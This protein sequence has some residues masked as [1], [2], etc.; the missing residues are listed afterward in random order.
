MPRPFG[1]LL[2]SKTAG[3][4][5]ES[6]P[7]AIAA[8]QRLARASQQPS[9]SSPAFQVEAS[10]DAT[11]FTPHKLAQFRVIVLQHV[12][13]EFL[14]ASQLDALRGFV[15][16]GGGVVGIHT[17]TTGMPSCES[18]CVDKEAWYQGLIGA[19]FDGH[20]EPQDGI[21]RVQSASHPILTRGAHGRDDGLETF[22]QSSMTRHW[23]DE[24]YN[25]KK[26]PGGNA[27]LTVLLSVDETSYEGGRL[28]D[29]HPL[30]WCQEFEGGR[31]FQTALG[32]FDAAYE[33]D[34][35]MGQA[36][37]GLLWA[38]GLL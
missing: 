38:A 19:A 37:S 18:G 28:G 3:Y 16:A 26:S 35:F 25:F 17:A 34:M 30:T 20:P 21:I 10:E 5:H 14:D 6:I 15:R 27:N 32:H 22:D 12:T 24:W 31:V 2:F 7:A 13:G 8:W 11:L 36:L 1:V 33:D 4:R 23:F 29:A 9:S